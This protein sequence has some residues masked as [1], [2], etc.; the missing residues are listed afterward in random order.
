MYYEFGSKHTIANP[1]TRER[2]HRGMTANQ[3][4]D[5]SGNTTATA[6][7]FFNHGDVFFKQRI[8]RNNHIRG[9][10]A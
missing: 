10:N 2:A 6:K 9:R 1:H 5:S 3:V 7:G 8:M 4:V